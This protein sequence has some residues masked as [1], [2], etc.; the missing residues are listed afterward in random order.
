[1]ITRKQPG[2]SRGKNVTDAMRKWK[3]RKGREFFLR[4]GR[5][6]GSGFRY[7]AKISVKRNL[8][9]CQHSP[10]ARQEFE[11]AFEIWTAIAQL[12]RLGLVGGR[13]ATQGSG[14]VTT[15]QLQPILAM[16]RFGLAGKPGFEEG[17]KQKVSRAVAGE[18]SSCTIGT[19]RAG[20]EP[21]NQQLGGWIAK[22]GNRL[23]PVFLVTVRA[24]FF[25]GDLTAIPDEAW[26]SLTSDD[27]LLEDCQ[28]SAGG[29]L[30]ILP[31][32]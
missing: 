18:H 12:I 29:Q 17:S 15:A 10:H 3:S 31:G 19:V 7:E 1:M 8:P 5:M 30:S 14:N 21:E 24:A 6:R 13:S 11:F 16:A 22:T 4:L 20:C 23:A 27:F 9:Q 26:A 25:S 2:E 28:W 32:Q